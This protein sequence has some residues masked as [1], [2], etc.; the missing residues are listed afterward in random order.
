MYCHCWC[1]AAAL[2]CYSS[3][4]VDSSVAQNSRKLAA[5]D[6]RQSTAL[7]GSAGF[8][9]P[10]NTEVDGDFKFL[11]DDFTIFFNPAQD[12]NNPGIPFQV[13]Q[14]AANSTGVVSGS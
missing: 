2:R 6:V 3:G 4:D 10:A 11:G 5:A 13:P 8:A 14:G 1:T 9:F 12:T 7:W